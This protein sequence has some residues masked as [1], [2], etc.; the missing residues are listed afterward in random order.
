MNTSFLKTTF[1]LEKS[2]I[3]FETVID[4]LEEGEFI[5][6]F[7]PNIIVDEDSQ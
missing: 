4:E 1:A 6:R 5:C 7:L 2:V 3:Y